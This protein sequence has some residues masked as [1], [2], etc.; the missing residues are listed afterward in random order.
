MAFAVERG[1]IGDALAV[2]VE[3]ESMVAAVNAASL[4]GIDEGVVVGVGVPLLD[5]RGLGPGHG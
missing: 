4:G 2:L 5:D 3:F 1:A